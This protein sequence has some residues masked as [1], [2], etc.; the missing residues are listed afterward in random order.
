MNRS[1][2]TLLSFTTLLGGLLGTLPA[3]ANGVTAEELANAVTLPVLHVGSEAE[4]SSEIETT[5]DAFGLSE[6]TALQVPQPILNRNT[7]TVPEPSGSGVGR[8]MHRE[9]PI[10]TPA[11]MPAETPSDM[12]SDMYRDGIQM[13][14]EALE[15]LIEQSPAEVSAIQHYNQGIEHYNE[16][17]DA[18]ALT[19]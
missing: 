1:G 19:S 8:P 16:G 5:S 13:P 11:E 15:M 6:D 7:I 2:L 9:L 17:E 10:E 3:S 18:Q 12:P 14:A 4:L